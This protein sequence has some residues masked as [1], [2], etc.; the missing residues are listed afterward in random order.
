MEPLA[1]HYTIVPLKECDI[2]VTVFVKFDRRVGYLPTHP[3]DSFSKYTNHKGRTRNCKKLQLHKPFRDILT[4]G[5]KSLQYLSFQ[6]SVKHCPYR[7]V[8]NENP[9]SK[10]LGWISK[11]TYYF[12]VHRY[13]PKTALK[14]V[15]QLSFNE[16]LAESITNIHSGRYVN[17][18]EK[19]SL[20]KNPV[21]G[22]VLALFKETNPDQYGRFLTTEGVKPGKVLRPFQHPHLKCINTIFRGGDMPFSLI[23]EGGKKGQIRLPA[24]TRESWYNFYHS[25]VYRTNNFNQ[26]A[27]EHIT[28]LV[29]HMRS[30]QNLNDIK[31][32]Y[33]ILGSYRP[34][35]NHINT[36]EGDADVLE[37]LPECF[38]LSFEAK[39]SESHHNTDSIKTKYYDKEKFEHDIHQ[40]HEP[41]RFIFSDVK[42]LAYIAFRKAVKH[43]S[44]TENIYEE[45]T[46][47]L[48][49]DSTVYY[50]YEFYPNVTVLWTVT[51]CKET[52]LT[53]FSG[54]YKDYYLERIDQLS[55]KKQ[56][57]TGLVYA[58]LHQPNWDTVSRNWNRP[59]C[60][61]CNSRFEY[62][63][64]HPL[65]WEQI[66]RSSN[67]IMAIPFSRNR[68]FP[69]LTLFLTTSSNWRFFC[70]NL[71]K[72]DPAIDPV[73]LKHLELSVQLVE[74]LD[75]LHIK[76]L[77]RN[78]FF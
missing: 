35:M 78:Y 12:D 40:P 24:Q 65:I 68:T 9:K 63:F 34:P 64:C 16:S 69:Q 4:H 50:R 10:D 46:D 18:V 53:S 25:F 15:W 33:W 49:Y 45:V 51:L 72:T 22:Y 26:E 39:L 44:Y 8:I 47:K 61:E 13:I 17:N 75:E 54:L 30:V 43:F 42:S 58:L 14:V 20:V 74:Y 23:W 77:C 67:N 36:L 29:N 66:Y 7:E 28:L 57:E 70:S 60:F 37:L 56:P 11:Y 55:L 48:G 27:K 59:C 31:S 62:C 2:S 41:L 1:Q 52:I 6:Q 3:R 71:L 73:L 5:L 76:E 19:I 21:T 32:D 38:N